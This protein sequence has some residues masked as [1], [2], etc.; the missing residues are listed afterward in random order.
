MHAS[1]MEFRSRIYWL[2]AGTVTR[3]S[4]STTCGNGS[5]FLRFQCHV[6]PCSHSTLIVFSCRTTSYS[7]RKN[8]LSTWPRCFI[9][10]SCLHV[11][12][13]EDRIYFVILTHQSQGSNPRL[14]VRKPDRLPTELSRRER[15]PLTLK[16][17]VIEYFRVFIIYR[18][19]FVR[20]V[21]L[22]S[23]QDLQLQSSL[24]RLWPFSTMCTCSR[25]STQSCTEND[26]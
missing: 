18:L 2:H 17:P 13:V 10:S 20:F 25:A 26:W 15:V 16:V 7:S 24:V 4:T 8:V 5:G 21:H 23:Q 22:V 9:G 19:R 3:L 12:E 14:F 6:Y 11:N 1:T